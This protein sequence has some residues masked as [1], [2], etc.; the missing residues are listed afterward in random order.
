MA[1]I[2]N[3]T[4][5]KSC[6]F[7]GWFNPL[8]LGLVCIWVGTKQGGEGLGDGLNNGN[9]DVLAAIFYATGFICV[10]LFSVAF[11]IIALVEQIRDKP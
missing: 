3:K 9:S 10:S 11:L 2:E 7:I 6:K 1:S 4:H 5:W 8:L